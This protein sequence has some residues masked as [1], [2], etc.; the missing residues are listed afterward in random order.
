VL[1]AK[2]KYN[3]PHLMMPSYMDN[4]APSPARSATLPLARRAGRGLGVEIF[5]GFAAAEVLFHEDGSVKGVATGDMGVARDGT[6]KPDYT[7]GL[8]LH[9]KYTSSPKARAAT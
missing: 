2:K 7:P 8:E 9:A 5:P 1:T 4:R 3:L 6:R